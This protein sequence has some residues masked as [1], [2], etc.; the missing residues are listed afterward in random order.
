MPTLIPLA[1]LRPSQNTNITHNTGIPVPQ[2]TGTRPGSN[3][4]Q[5][6]EGA[7]GRTKIGNST[8]LGV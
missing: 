1:C 3:A 4:G 5:H 7:T 2:G 8:G 6:S